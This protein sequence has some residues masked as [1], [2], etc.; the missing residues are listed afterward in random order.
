MSRLPRL[1]FAITVALLVLGA[2]RY[3]G[4][5]S[6]I[7]GWTDATNEAYARELADRLR[8]VNVPAVSFRVDV[9]QQ[10]RNGCILVDLLNSFG[11]STRCFAVRV[12]VLSTTGASGTNEPSATE[13]AAAV[14]A[15]ER[16]L[17]NLSPR[18]DEKTRIT[19]VLF[20]PHEIRQTDGG[21][22]V[23]MSDPVQLSREM[24]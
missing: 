5:G 20:V 3:F 10:Y 22:G 9:A 6:W 17:D 16:A 4:P 2:I 12:A 21:L 18:S 23:I 1:G 8:D 7:K 13:Q 24:N 14:Q 11:N 15:V 19:V